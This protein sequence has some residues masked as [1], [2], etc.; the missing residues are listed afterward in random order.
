[1]AGDEHLRVQ[2]QQCVAQGTEFDDV[3][4]ERQGVPDVE[5][6]GRDVKSP[7]APE[8]CKREKSVYLVSCIA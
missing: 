3:L 7:G 4:M 8:R 2:E 1:M 6:G 5:T